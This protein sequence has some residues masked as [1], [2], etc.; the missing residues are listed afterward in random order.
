MSNKYKKLIQDRLN[1]YEKVT[2]CLVCNSEYFDWKPI[3]DKG[4]GF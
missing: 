4:N 3:T 2:Q 1:I